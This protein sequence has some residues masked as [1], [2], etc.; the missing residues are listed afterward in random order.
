MRAQSFVR[1]DPPPDCVLLD[2]KDDAST[3]AC[4]YWLDDFQ[5]D[6]SMDSAVRSAVWYALHRAGI[7]DAMLYDASWEEWGRRTDL[8][9]DRDH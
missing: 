8:P 5:R 9:V 4:R 6:D 2:F 7:E 1:S 3:Y